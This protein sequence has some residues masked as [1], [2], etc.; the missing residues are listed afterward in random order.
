M[1]LHPATAHIQKAVFILL[2][3]KKDQVAQASKISFA[4]VYNKGLV[5]LHDS[6]KVS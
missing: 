3:E 4:K 5:N 6:A 2:V 1:I